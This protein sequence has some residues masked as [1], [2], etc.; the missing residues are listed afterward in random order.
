MATV[1]GFTASRMLEIESTSIVDGSIDED[2]HLILTTKG[3]ATIDAGSVFDPT[4][5]HVYLIPE[6]GRKWYLGS[7]VGDVLSA[8]TGDRF[9][10]ADGAQKDETYRWDGDSWEFIGLFNQNPGLFRAI[11]TSPA[12]PHTVP[13][14]SGDTEANAALVS[15][16][17]A[18][19]G[20]GLITNAT[21]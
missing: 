7:A 9:T 3:G 10:Y 1:T 11:F 14:V 5:G 17:A 16:I 19:E 20:L 4:H 18:L 15:L 6:P 8:Q 12:Y 21:T 13:E 2:G